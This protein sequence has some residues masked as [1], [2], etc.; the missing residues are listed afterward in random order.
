M[1]KTL[2]LLIRY[3]GAGCLATLVHLVIFTVLLRWFGPVLS[4]FCAGI[5]GAGTSYYLARHWVF[6]ERPCNGVRFT[7]TAASQVASNTLIVGLL[8]DWDIPAF[9]AQ[10]TAM[11]VVTAQGFTINHF[12]V[13]KHGSK[14]THTL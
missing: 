7:I 14:R 5:S 3:L 6:A 2:D 13:F 11:A 9:L 8:T 4:T 12:W 10:L 1:P